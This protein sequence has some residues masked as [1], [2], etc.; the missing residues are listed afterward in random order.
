MPDANV[1]VAVVGGGVSGLAAA[2]ELQ[3]RGVRHVLLEGSARIGGVIR[4]DR[5]DGFTIDGGPDAL[6]I[7]KTAGIELCRELGLGDRLVPTLPPRTAFIVRAGRLHPLPRHSVLGIPTRLWPLASTRLLSAAGRARMAL[8]LIRPGRAPDGGAD[9]SIASFF[10]RRFG[11]EAVDYIAE[12]LLAGIHAGHVDRLSIRALFP[13]LAEAEH[14]HG[15]VMRALA[16]RR[17]ARRAPGGPFRSLPGGVGELADALAGALAPGVIRIGDGVR[18]LRGPAPYRLLLSGGETV[19]AGQVV[20]AVPAHIAAEL[21]RPLDPELA[22]LCG[23]IPHTSTATVTLGY[24]RGAIRH[25]LRGTG[26]VVPRIER[27][28]SVMAGTWVSSKWPDRAPPGQALLRGFVGGARDT[29]AL[30]RSDAELIDA[31]HRDLAHLLDIEGRPS[32]ARV[33]RWPRLNPQYEVGHLERLAAIDARL[34]RLPGL[35]LIGAGFRGVGIPDCIH[36]GRAAGA[37]ASRGSGP[38]PP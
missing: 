29:A 7:E 22:E 27:G 16:A 23:G 36:Q 1:R 4:T 25:D 28:L 21:V 32:L 17:R 20:L 10:A 9:E 14:T 13:R 33:Y 5:V 18:E 30:D 31:V 8:D 15:S 26:F 38:S 37:A 6:L 3:V 19:S 35:R 11:R 2:Y 12:P 34:A 24:P